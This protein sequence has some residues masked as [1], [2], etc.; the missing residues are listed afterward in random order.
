V[1]RIEREPQMPPMK[2]SISG[3]LVSRESVSQL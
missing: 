1:E 2:I 3:K